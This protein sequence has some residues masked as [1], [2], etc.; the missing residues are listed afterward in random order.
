MPAM[1]IGRIRIDSVRGGGG[2]GGCRLG[3]ITL[4]L[5][6]SVATA[7]VRFGGGGGGGGRCESEIEAA[8]PNVA[9]VGGTMPSVDDGETDS[10]KFEY[11]NIAV[12]S[13]DDSSIACALASAAA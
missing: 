8:L 4:S 5:V 3:E 2:G 6:D 11:G 1:A 12:Q 13:D 10:P 9:I 7:T